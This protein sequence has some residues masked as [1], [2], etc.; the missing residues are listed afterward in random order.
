M[1]E[2]LQQGGRLV[3]FAEGR[4]STTTALM[5]LFEGTGF[6][7]HK[8]NARVITAYL[9]NA[10]RS[11]F[12][13]HTGWTTWFPRVS[14][15]VGR[16]C[17]P[18]ALPAMSNLATR[19]HRTRWLRDMMLRQQFDVEWTMGHRTVLAAV[20]STAARLPGKPILEDITFNALTYRRLMVGVE[21]LGQ[22]WS[23]LFDG[24]PGRRPSRKTST[25]S[26]TAS[27]TGPDAK[28][29]VS[30]GSQGPSKMEPPQATASDTKE[31]SVA[32][33][34]VG[35]RIGVLLP[36]VNAMPVTVLSLW[37][38]GKVPAILNFS[39]GIPTMLACIQLAE[40]QH[41]ITSSAFLEKARL[42]LDPL[43]QAGIQ[44][45]LLEDIRP[46]ISGLS[47]LRAL[48]KHSMDCGAGFREA[49]C[50]TPSSNQPLAAD[51]SLEPDHSPSAVILFTSGSEGVPKGVELSHRNLMANLHQIQ[52]HLDVTDH[53]RF[54]NAMPLFHSFGLTACTLLPLVR[55]L[56]TFLYPSP[57][58]YRVVPTVIY[59]RSCTVMVGTNTFLNGYARR[60][61]PYDFQSIKYLVAGAEKLQE[62][63]ANT[64]ARQFGVRVLEG[65][66]ATEC[67]PV[68]AANSRMEPRFGSVGR[69]LPGIEYRLEPV[70]GVEEGGR[71][72]VRGPNVMRGYLNADANA[73]FLALN[74]WYDTGDLA[75]VDEDGFIYLLGRLKRFAKI[76]GE[77]VSLTAVE[78]AMVGAF[79]Q[80]GARCEVAVVAVPDADKGER[81]IA[82]V[83]DSSL[84]LSDLR[85]AIHETGLGNLCVPREIVYRREIPKLGT[86]KVNYQE[87]LAGILG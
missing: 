29:G 5:K 81:L 42:N 63:T 44:I 22:Q 28:A 48:L 66:G 47:K 49:E 57:L 21:L 34:G 77:M 85:A 86:G 62:N 56:Y 71:L 27:G 16:A 52:A 33:G 80:C 23:R 43:R 39:S 38:V 17:E 32:K 14:L 78:D 45:H 41:V 50:L 64:W 70:E 68:L 35:Q 20:A 51:E 58:H 7:I 6:L 15:H 83:N 55:G 3:L 46:Q 11:P 18:P 30:S 67:S 13:R 82:I 9:R 37:S 79:P 31:E 65:Y 76:S 24:V 60:A 12:V 61:H 72:F 74:G 59:D 75:R 8:T 87:L 1:A 2:F 26:N 4:I 25:G 10:V 54:F 84:T 19:E 40:V 36:N 73:R 69:F 53:E